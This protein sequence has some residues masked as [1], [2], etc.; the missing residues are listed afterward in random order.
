MGAPQAAIDADLNETLALAKAS[1]LTDQ[2][3]ASRVCATTYP[4]CK[5]DCGHPACPC[6]GKGD[7]VVVNSKAT[8]ITT[9]VAGC[10]DKTALVSLVQGA[11][12]PAAAVVADAQA[13]P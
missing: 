11:P 1:A 3:M 4:S 5:F 9:A 2:Q 12:V 13:K 7:M 6:R 8:A 10:A